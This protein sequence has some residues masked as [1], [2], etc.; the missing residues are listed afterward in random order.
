M[1]NSIQAQLLLPDDAGDFSL[2]YWKTLLA[3]PINDGTA[4]LA[5][6]RADVQDFFRLHDVI[7]RHE[8]LARIPE[9]SRDELF[10]FLPVEDSQAFLELREAFMRDLFFS[11]KQESPSLHETPL[12]PL[13][14]INKELLLRVSN[15][16]EFEELKY[17]TAGE[18][19]S[20]ARS[21][22]L[23]ARQLFDALSHEEAKVI[24]N[25]ADAA[26]RCQDLQ[27]S[28]D[29]LAGLPSAKTHTKRHKTAL[30]KK[31]VIAQEKAQQ[32]QQAA[33]QAAQQV[34]LT[35]LQDA[36]SSMNDIFCDLSLDDESDSGA[37]LGDGDNRGSAIHQILA[38]HQAIKNNKLIK[39]IADLAGRFEV[40]AMDAQFDKLRTDDGEVTEINMGQDYTRCLPEEIALLADPA[41]ED[42]FYYKFTNHQLLQVEVVQEFPAGRG[43]IIIVVD[44]SGSMD[45]ARE[46]WSKAVA[47]GLVFLARKNKRRIKL[48]SFSSA[49]LEVDLTNK[50][51]PEILQAAAHFYNGGT[52]YYAFMGKVTALLATGMPRA[53]VVLISDGDA[54]VSEPDIV[55]WRKTC[56]SHN[57][58]CYSVYLGAETPKGKKNTAEVS[59]LEKLSDR[60]FYLSDNDLNVKDSSTKGGQILKSIFA[61]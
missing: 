61:V 37:G 10:S 11:L 35:Q 18:P 6:D 52:N 53:D 60:V 48:I 44:E 47:L 28:L 30:S 3:E 54:G 8:Q 9:E 22:S 36:V 40:I 5:H 57:A 17:L 29:A 23:I 55:A 56:A 24:K 51:M 15:L 7:T 39:K 1:T 33:Q 58:R 38:A 2:A 25:A 43:D 45:G 50:S 46:I 26:A 12:N 16:P 4:V 41:T 32:A 27:E 31:L 19:R 49:A 14:T 42:L 13:Y 21:C 59:L 34:D 20:A